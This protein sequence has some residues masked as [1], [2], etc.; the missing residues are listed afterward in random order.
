MCSV[1]VHSRNWIGE[2]E[3][4]QCCQGQEQCLNKHTAKIIAFC[5]KRWWD[6][7]YQPSHVGKN[8]LIVSSLYSLISFKIWLINLKLRQPCNSICLQLIPHTLGFCQLFTWRDWAS[9]YF[10]P[11]STSCHCITALHRIVSSM[12]LKELGRHTF[13]RPQGKKLLLCVATKQW[14]SF[15]VSRNP[16]CIF[17]VLKLHWTYI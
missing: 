6:N 3:Y 4:L 9:L 16:D 17:T 11:S 8:S 5:S 7:P 1:L 14:H 2:I 15:S 13:S 12:R 10:L